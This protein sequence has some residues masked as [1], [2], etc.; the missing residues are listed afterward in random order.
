MMTK[1]KRFEQLVQR[2]STDIFR[3]A[4]WLC[5]NREIAE[6]LVQEAFTRAWK[7]LH[8]LKDGNKE[9]AW[10][11]T[12]LRNE[13]AR[14]FQRVQPDLVDIEDH[15][16][17]MS[18]D[19]GLEPEEQMERR[20]LRKAMLDLEEEYREPLIMQVIHGFSCREIAET[21]ELTENAVMTRIFRAKQKV[22]EAL[23]EQTASAMAR[24]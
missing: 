6:D 1:Q 21:L 20:I 17:S 4:L 8:Q 5:G 3:Y 12:I 14:R 16:W 23:T 10:L 22:K 19:T 2:Y 18:A 9:K 7:N 13:N 15:A 24:L 11:M